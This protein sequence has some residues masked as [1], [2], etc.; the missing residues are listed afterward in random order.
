MDG[1]WIS[2]AYRS[3][4]PDESIRSLGSLASLFGIDLAK[5]RKRTLVTQGTLTNPAGETLHLHFKVYAT[6][7]NTFHGL[8]RRSRGVLE[9]R[10]LINF[11]R[12]EIR[13]PDVLAWGYRRRAAGL[14]SDQSFLMTRT[15]PGAIALRE[16]WTGLEQPNSPLV[17]RQIIDQLARQTRTLHARRFFHQD[18][19]WRNLLVDRENA[20][21]WIDC[22]NGYFGRFPPRQRH[23]RIKDLATL[24]KVAKDRCSES[25]R[26]RFLGVYLDTEDEAIID[27]WARAVVHY[28][29]RRQD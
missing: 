24:D 25:E 10:N 9:A 26:R 29:D 17:R 13:A 27:Q 14:C 11:S 1:I 20:V 19:K 12:W 21:Y 7:L 6:R 4:F 23:G 8:A 16:H 15:V 3:W 28:R 2:P 18:L 22:P 5:H